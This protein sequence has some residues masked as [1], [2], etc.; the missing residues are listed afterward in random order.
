MI[1]P[2]ARWRRRPSDVAEL[3]ALQKRILG[4]ALHVV[5]RGG[6]VGYATCSP[7]IEETVDVVAPILDE[8]RASIVPVPGATG[9]LDGTMQLWPHVHGTDAMFMAL[10]RRED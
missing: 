1:R 4:A 10:L 2:V 9:P 3:V 5:R 7:L 8:G 6:L